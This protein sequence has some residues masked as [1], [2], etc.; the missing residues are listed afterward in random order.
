M[1]VEHAQNAHGTYMCSRHAS[2]T[3]RVPFSAASRFLSLSGLASKLRKHAS[4]SSRKHIH[5]RAR[6]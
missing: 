2:A 3:G 1:D 6:S 5:T 4:V